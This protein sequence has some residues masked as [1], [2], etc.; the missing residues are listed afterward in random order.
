[1][2]VEEIK[3]LQELAIWMTG[4]GYDF[5]QHKYFVE[6][7][8]LLGKPILEAMEQYAK[9]E[10][11]KLLDKIIPRTC[12]SHACLQIMLDNTVKELNKLKTK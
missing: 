1:M 10:R 5:T 12:F 2:T 6:N 11:I 9:Q 7:R 8:H 4:C 3:Q